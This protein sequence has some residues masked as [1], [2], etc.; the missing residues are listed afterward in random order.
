MTDVVLGHQNKIILDLLLSWCLTFF[1]VDLATSVGSA[2]M[3][4]RGEGGVCWQGNPG[5][6]GGF[7]VGGRRDLQKLGV[8]DTPSSAEK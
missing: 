8:G 5:G 4:V 6:A 2:D 7:G 3:L 1:N